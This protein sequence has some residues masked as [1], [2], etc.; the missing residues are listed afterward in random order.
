MARTRVPR[1]NGWRMADVVTGI[2]DGEGRLVRADPRLARLQH[3]AGGL[4]G[5]AFAVPALAALARLAHSLGVLVSRSIIVAE[6]D[7]DLELFVRA[8]RESDVVALGISGWTIRPPRQPWLVAEEHPDLSGEK[9]VQHA[10]IRW[11]VDTGLNVTQY[12]GLA[13]AGEAIGAP[14]T[15]LFRLLDDDD[16]TMPM[17]AALAG[18][19]DI[20]DQPATLHSDPSLEF[21]LDA[22]V[23]RDLQ[24]RFAGYVGTARPVG[25]HAFE[26][27]PEPDTSSTDF[28]ARLDG[29]LRAPLARIAA[30]ADAIGTQAE[31]P[32]RRDYA[33]Y[34][35][36]IGSAARHLLALVDDL[37]DLQAIE[38]GG[39]A[40]D[41]EPID[42]ADVARRA[43]GL[44][45]VRASDRGVRIDRPAEGET[46]VA[47]ADFRR[48]LQIVV[49]LVG[50]AI[51]YSP[52]GS[53][54]WLRSERDDETAVLIVADQGKGI[55]AG[56]QARIFE[57]FERV[58][59]GEPEGS[60]LGLYI[61][62]RLA[63]A[64]GGDIT[65]DSAPGQGARFVLTLPSV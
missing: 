52:E 20:T 53:H 48:A 43:A 36:D 23:L 65:V 27:E 25:R 1:A 10:A 46:L 7:H 59:P 22:L 51:R 40:I 61:S 64:M 18:Q 3:A 49:N 33:D 56:D 32:L 5:G 16:G 58:D 17:L 47:K 8:R 45:Q 11:S 15:R 50:N 28:I 44:L 24:G 14:L 6:G 12:D 13:G 35:G 57:K 63:R 62:R 41:A 39:F 4:V 29:A 37:S 54:I 26:P 9:P 2:V 30:R 21:M 38:A 34:A 19:R 31:G 42:L 60:G 55:A